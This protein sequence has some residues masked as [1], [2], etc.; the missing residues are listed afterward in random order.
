MLCFRKFLVS[1]KFM[2]KRE[3]EVSRVSFGKIFSHSAEKFRKGTHDGVTDF[4]YPKILCLRGLSHEFSSNFFCIAVS[5]NFA[6]ETFCSVFRKISGSG[7]VY[8]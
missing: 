1:K 8:G 4:G 5:K 7:K 6:G 2:D 3:G